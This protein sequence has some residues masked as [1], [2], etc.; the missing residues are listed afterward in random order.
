VT[1]APPTWFRR[2]LAAPVVAG[3]VRSRDGRR[4][5]FRRWGTGGRPVLLVHGGAA[6]ARWWDHVGPLLADADTTVV[7]V[8][9]AGH[10]DSDPRDRYDLTGW[11]SDLI[12]MAGDP[13]VVGTAGRSPVLVGHSMGGLVT[14]TAATE[15][16]ARLAG[17]VAIDSPIGDREPEQSAPDR[18]PRPHRRYPSRAEILARFRTLPEQDVTLP[19]VVEHVAEQSI[20]HE[21]D[22]WIWKHDP[23]VLRRPFSS[24][25]VPDP[26]SCRLAL[27]R[28]EDGI[29]AARTLDFLAATLGPA[30]SVIELPGTA[31]HM[32]LDQPIAL[33]AALRVMLAAWSTGDDELA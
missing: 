32:M 23:A 14:W 24:E 7:A 6:H 19:Y 31:H 9:L 25:G 27:L 1:E 3:S 5:A 17:V 20:R 21:P 11:A 18:I 10:G 16:G 28:A 12:D 33:V 8:D 2:A 29:V 4:L 15:H 30:V 22:G 13:G 26:L